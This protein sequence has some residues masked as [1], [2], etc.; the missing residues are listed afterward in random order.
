M[1]NAEFFNT[2]CLRE[3]LDPG[4]VEV[5]IDEI[6]RAPLKHQSSR[7]GKS[8]VIPTVPGP[9]YVTLIGYGAHIVSYLG[10]KNKL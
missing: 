5:P 10:R 6:P 1:S 4:P 9:P 2:L 3:L 7:K 8:H